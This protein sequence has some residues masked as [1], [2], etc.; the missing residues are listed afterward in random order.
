M[1]P[2]NMTFGKILSVISFMLY[3]RW[4]EGKICINSL[5]IVNNTCEWSVSQ[6]QN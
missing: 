2:E 5:T 1:E 3:L 6:E 4:A